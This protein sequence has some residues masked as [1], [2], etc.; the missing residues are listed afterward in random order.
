MH[1]N[2]DILLQNLTSKEHYIALLEILLPLR[3]H[4]MIEIKHTTNF[5]EQFAI[6]ML[7]KQT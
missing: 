6:S 4:Y 5:Q 1:V 2:A 7:I 3:K